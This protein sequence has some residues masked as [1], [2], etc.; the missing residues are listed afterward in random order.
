M[1]VALGSLFLYLLVNHLIV[2]GG[3]ILSKLIHMVKL[4]DLKP[5]LLSKVILKYVDLIIVIL[6][7]RS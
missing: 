6:S 3:G 7:L 4:F 2:V 1:L 5:T